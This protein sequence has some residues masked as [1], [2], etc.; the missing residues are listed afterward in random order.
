MPEISVQALV[1]AK[2]SHVTV[3][4]EPVLLNRTLSTFELSSEAV[5]VRVTDVLEVVAAPWF[6]WIEPVGAVLSSFMSDRT[7]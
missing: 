7:L 5:S 6:I 1:S 4:N 3:S 2:S